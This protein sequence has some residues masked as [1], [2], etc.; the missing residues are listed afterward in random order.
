MSYDL[1]QQ[2]KD[3]IK[4]TSKNRIIR[5][6]TKYCNNCCCSLSKDNKVAHHDHITGDYIS[7]L[8]NKCNLDFKYKSFMPVYIHNLKSY[9]A[10]FLILAMTKYGYQAD[11]DIDNIS[12]IPN[13]EEKFISFSK[14][15]KVGEYYNKKT[16]QMIN[17]M[18]EIRFLDTLAFMVTSLDKLTKNLKKQLQKYR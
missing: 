2:N 6:D 1:V 9:D 17:I 12:V 18:Y 3:K 8:C 13:N 4:F 14:S 10:H 11:G 5:Y 7:T 15:I 16:D